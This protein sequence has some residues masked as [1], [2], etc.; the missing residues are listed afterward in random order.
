MIHN[1]LLMAL[2]SLLTR[3]SYGL[4]NIVGLAIGL[5]ASLIMLYYV[6]QE[7]S[8]DR[9][10]TKHQ[11][12]GRITY[13]VE[14]ESESKGIAKVPFPLKFVLLDE[15]P[16]VDKVVRFYNSAWL[17]AE[18]LIKSGGD[19]FSEEG[20][21]FADPEIFSVFDFR[22]IKGNPETVFSNPKSVVI[23]ERIA[24]KYFG[25][26]DPI[27]KVINYQNETDL[28]ITGVVMDVPGNSHIKFNFLAPVELQRILWKSPVNNHYDFEE[29]WK[30]SGAWLYVLFHENHDTRAFEKKIQKIAATFMMPDSQRKV[31]FDIQRLTDIHLHSDL[32]SEL[33]TNGS[34]TQ[35]L[36]FVGIAALILLIA[37]FN[38]INLS[39]ARAAERA[40]EVGI[41]KVMGALRTQLILQFV[42]EAIVITLFAVIIA[43]LMT[44]LFLPWCS[45]LL[46][47]Q[48]DIYY[49]SFDFLLYVSLGVLIVGTTAGLYP[50]FVLS[51]FQPAKTLKGLIE[52]PTGGNILL[53]RMLVIVQFSISTFLIT[54]VII[55]KSQL[56]F[57]SEKKLGFEKDQILVLTNGNRITKGYDVF[58][59]KVLAHREVKEMYRGYIP[60]VR[61]WTNSFDVEGRPGSVSLGLRYVDNNFIEMFG[62]RLL[63][64]R[65]FKSD[66]SDTT[67]HAFINE[68]AVNTFQWKNEDAIGKRI[69]YVGGSDNRTEYKLEIIGVINDANFESLHNGVGPQIFINE[70]WG[71]IALKSDPKSWAAL[72]PQI[73]KE[74]RTAFPEWPFEYKFLDEDFS[75]L[76]AREE[77]LAD[78]ISFFTILAICIACMGLMG[79]V[80]LTTSQRS[81]EIG[82]RKVMGASNSSIWILISRTYL[83]LLLSA[84]IISTP[85]AYYI[86][87]Q[88]LHGFAFRIEINPFPFILGSGIILLI[89]MFTICVQTFKASIQNPTRLIKQE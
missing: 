86:S 59:Q 77:K 14:S 56:R 49:T 71:G 67:H 15:Y 21:L 82:I 43:G 69:H 64:G 57:I 51:R 40:K 31:T 87:N 8:Y 28:Q 32:V 16:E 48:I 60:G 25:D 75:Q 4:I 54:S 74:W 30:W 41:R 34:L 80:S 35:V 38:F 58:K 73:E 9:F 37:I 26:G 76:Y 85:I 22:L 72:I 27:G 11:I 3:W 66:Y 63:A 88:W 84:L 46:G 79:I 55:V 78:A 47:V 20:F 10:H 23:S 68:A 42:G 2:R 44:E 53:R 13:K 12:I 39:T 33:E 45:R 7:F 89:A 36:G 65:D 5:A 81:R 50:A 83:G 61:G 6:K 17:G 1:Y 24:N 62:L 29:D 70:V 18:T 19:I 52:K